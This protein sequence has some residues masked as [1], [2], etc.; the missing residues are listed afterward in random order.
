MVIEQWTPLLGPE[1]RPID[2]GNPQLHRHPA[3]NG[4][5][6]G[7]GMGPLVFRIDPAQLDPVWLEPAGG[8]SRFRIIP[9][10]G[11]GFRA[12]FT[13]DLVILDAANQVVASDGTPVNP[14]GKL[15]GHSICATGRAV[16]FD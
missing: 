2:P 11:P 15:A 9:N 12:A 7:V 14:D 13:P 3:G 8:N 5:C 16:L 4:V 10:F 1:D 6:E